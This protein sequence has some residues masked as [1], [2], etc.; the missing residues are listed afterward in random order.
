MSASTKSVATKL[1]LKAGQRFL[2][3]NA[4]RGYMDA[5]G[6]VP[7]GVM[8][9]TKGEGPFD[10]IQALVS[11]HDELSRDL[12][13]GKRH[14][15]STTPVW[16]TYPKGGGGIPTD[17]NRDRIR[18]FVEARGWK[19]VALFAVDATWSALRLRAVT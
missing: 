18:A 7:S 10:V 19:A 16:I 15:S 6:P 5:L 12:A 13:V 1:G 11:S 14:A 8:V 4:P 17:L 3:L 9:K 2:V